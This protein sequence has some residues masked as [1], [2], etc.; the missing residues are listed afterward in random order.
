MLNLFVGKPFQISVVPTC[1]NIGGSIHLYWIIVG[2]SGDFYC[3]GTISNLQVD[4]SLL[5]AHGAKHTK[6]KKK[7]QAS[8]TLR[9]RIAKQKR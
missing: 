6:K 3:G 5:T 9:S 1:P 7:L 2:S 8:W 4:R